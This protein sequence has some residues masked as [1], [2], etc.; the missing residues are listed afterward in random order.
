MEIK[1]DCFNNFNNTKDNIRFLVDFVSILYKDK[2]LSINHKLDLI[3][4][5]LAK[6][7]FDTPICTLIDTKNNISVNAAI[8]INSKCFIGCEFEIIDNGE[9]VKNYNMSKQAIVSIFKDE[10]T[11][12]NTLSTYYEKYV[13]EIT[14]LANE[15]NLSEENEE[16]L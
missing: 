8:F 5:A 14:L 9:K 16:V 7:D 12:F 4:Q 6:R 11:L 15:T 13:D 1:Y 2:D 3:Q 10:D